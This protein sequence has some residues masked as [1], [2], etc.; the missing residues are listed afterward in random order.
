MV[1][2][3]TIFFPL[4][5]FFRLRTSLRSVAIH[6]ANKTHTWT[7]N[8]SQFSWVLHSL[9]LVLPVADVAAVAHSTHTLTHL[10]K[11]YELFWFE[12]CLSSLHTHSVSSSAPL[13]YSIH[14]NTH[15]CTRCYRCVSLRYVVCYVCWR[16]RSLVR[17]CVHLIFFLLSL[18]A[19]LIRSLSVVRFCACVRVFVNKTYPKTKIHRAIQRVKRKRERKKNHWHTNGNV[20]IWFKGNRVNTWVRE[21]P[22]YHLKCTFNS[23]C[24]VNIRFI[25]FSF[26]VSRFTSPSLLISCFPCCFSRRSFRSVN[27]S[28]S[29]SCCCHFCT[30][31]I[32]SLILIEREKDWSRR[33]RENM[34]LLSM[35]LAIVDAIQMIPWIPFGLIILLRFIF[36]FVFPLFMPFSISNSA[37]GHNN[38]VSTSVFRQRTI[39]KKE[40]MRLKTMNKLNNDS[41]YTQ[42][43]S[44]INK[45]KNRI[46]INNFEYS[47]SLWIAVIFSILVFLA[48]F[49]HAW[50]S[51]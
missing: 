28:M 27:S 22:N 4:L 18:F 14:T 1:L 16:A 21:K 48:H 12:F 30:R 5:L 17:V 24:S 50:V 43:L 34:L 44:D 10:Y 32:F 31:F 29:S 45:K 15:T 19:S 2:L 3:W 38:C 9:L 8:N 11:L 23:V 39:A 6:R 20:C 37:R 41:A 33:E 7:N 13:H 46:I 51:I 40:F 26:S 36:L 42:R 47:H 25:W 49:V 35:S